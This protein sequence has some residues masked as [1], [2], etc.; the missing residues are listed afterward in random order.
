MTQRATEARN[1]ASMKID[2]LPTREVLQIINN[3]DI[4]VP[5][6]IAQPKVLTQIE[7]IVDAVVD[8][9]NR[10][11]RLFYTGA[12]TSGRLGIL[13][14]A[15]CVP[16]Y[17]TDP[18]MVQGLIAGGKTALV[19]AVEGAEDSVEL[20]IQDLKDRNLTEKDFVLGLAAS[21]STPYVIGG[22]DYAR[23]IGAK[24]GALSCNE[25]ALISNHADI[26]IEAVVGAEVV[27]GSTRMKAGT[28]EK[29]ILNMISTT[30]MI[31][32]GKVYSNLMVDVKPTNIKLVDRAI[33]IISEATGVE[34]DEAQKFYEEAQHQPKV[35][36]V[37]INAAVSYEVAENA[38]THE[39][40]FI[41]KALQFLSQDGGR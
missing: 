20:G 11:G 8:S 37:M 26:A 32:I 19:D 40:G 39:R 22:L 33:R 15:E 30:S 4:N 24:T 29:L 3:E 6:V 13:D 27:T 21:G 7:R 36:I 25:D 38:L 2:E 35:A 18:E 9:F 1:P 31:K 16:T 17:G 14:A 5:Q 41:A 10:G 28:V 12:G 23:S 34:Y